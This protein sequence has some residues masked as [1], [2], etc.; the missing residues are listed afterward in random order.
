M[1]KETD[2]KEFIN[3]KKL[4]ILVAIF[5]GLATLLVAWAG[6]I[7]SLHGGIQAINFTKSNN[8]AAE[9]NAEYNLFFQYVF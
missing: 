5:L 4:E 3:E 2:K 9:G 1:K 6:W 7:G 8:L